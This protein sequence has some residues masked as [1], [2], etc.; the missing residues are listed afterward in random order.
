M[1]ICIARVPYV[2]HIQRSVNGTLTTGKQVAFQSPSK[3]IWPNSWVV[4]IVRQWIPDCRTSRSEEATT[5]GAAADTWNS[6]L[7]AAVT[8]TILW[9]PKLHKLAW[10]R[11]S[12][13]PFIHRDF[14]IFFIWNTGDFSHSVQPNHINDYPPNDKWRFPHGQQGSLRRSSSR[15]RHFEPVRG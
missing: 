5:E 2:K 9:M 1:Y 12:C 8:V 14:F 4:Q 3:L 11:L 10:Q 13:N 6:Q 7:M 15:L